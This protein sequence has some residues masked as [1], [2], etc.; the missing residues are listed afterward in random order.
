MKLL[1]VYRVKV[2]LRNY[3]GDDEHREE[4]GDVRGDTH[5]APELDG[6]PFLM[7][8]LQ[9][10][11]HIRRDCVRDHEMQRNRDDSHHQPTAP[12]GQKKVA[13]GVDGLE[14]DDEFVILLNLPCL[15]IFELNVFS[16]LTIFFRYVKQIEDTDTKACQKSDADIASVI[17][18][19]VPPRT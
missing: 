19:P 8:T 15:G 18:D 1:F 7:A 3:G 17:K 11:V 12:K 13:N 14:Q 16:D 5:S 10:I 9:T 6:R 4:S 2:L